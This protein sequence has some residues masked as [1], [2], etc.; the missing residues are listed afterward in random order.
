MNNRIDTLIKCLKEKESLLEKLVLL[1]D[2][3]R[4]HIVD[5]DMQGLEAKRVSKLKI[6]EQLEECKFSCK[7][8]LEDVAPAGKAGSPVKLSTVISVAPSSRRDLLLRAQRRLFDLT[9]LLNRSNRFNRDLLYGSLST[10][11]RSLE[12]INKRMGRGVSTY[13]NAGS[14]ITGVAGARL[15][16]GEI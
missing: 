2:E 5:L 10:V 4:E 9:D 13:S 7:K 15:V 12:F 8:A 11:N 6:I 1:L 14:V 16:S 3:E